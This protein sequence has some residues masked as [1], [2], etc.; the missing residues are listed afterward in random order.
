MANQAISDALICV[1]ALEENGAELLRSELEL[2]VNAVREQ[3]QAAI[4]ALRSAFPYTSAQAVRA[5]SD[6]SRRLYLQAIRI[7][8]EK[9]PL[10][11]HEVT[12]DMP[13][14]LVTH[15]LYADRTREPEIKRLNPGVINPNRIGAGTLL[16]VYAE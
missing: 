9:P 15:K 12:A 13:L 11:E 16:E 4:D 6:L 2:E 8:E 14:A 1:D 5:L 10:I 3:I 7:L